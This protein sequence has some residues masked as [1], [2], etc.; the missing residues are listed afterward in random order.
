MFSQVWRNAYPNIDLVTDH[1][2]RLR[3]C[4]SFER[5]NGRS[6]QGC[7]FTDLHSL[8]TLPWHGFTN[9]LQ[10]PTAMV[11][12]IIVNGILGFA[13]LI[14]IL[15]CIQNLADALSTTTGFPIVEIF[16]QVTR[17]NARAAS[18][19]TS[20]LIVMACLAT[21]PCIASAARV[22]WAFARD[23]G[24]PFSGTLSKVDEK[25]GVPTISVIVSTVLLAFL[26]LLNIASTT[27]FNAILSLGVVGLYVSY[28]LPVMLI[29]YQ[30][31]KTPHLLDYGPFKLGRWGL[32]V[33]VVSI[34]YTIFTSIF[35]LFPPYQ[36]VS[37][38]NLNYA[39]VV[40][41]GVLVV[42]VVYWFCYGRRYYDGPV[43]E[44]IAARTES[45]A[46]KA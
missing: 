2:L 15:F 39:P 33:N 41:G 8:S 43:V 28:L 18:A 25:R 31:L 23:S 35:L 17:G 7:K 45:R 14:A 20:A 27:A 42:S 36:P 9:I 37:A 5:G 4:H 21:V 10:V 29:F 44:L 22:L 16:Y 1:M 38:T 12:T 34:V 3:C 26:G 6:C 30:R 11:G 40:L 24:V 13:F 19:M 46:S 32:L